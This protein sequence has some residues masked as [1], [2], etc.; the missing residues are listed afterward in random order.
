MSI[1][2]NLLKSFHVSSKNIINLIFILPAFQTLELIVME[3]SSV[4]VEASF[5]SYRLAGYSVTIYP[6][7]LTPPLCNLWHTPHT[8]VHM[9][10]FWAIHSMQLTLFFPPLIPEFK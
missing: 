1:L 7:D 4:T 8:Q 10:F 3:L 9:G 2:R 6:P 5:C